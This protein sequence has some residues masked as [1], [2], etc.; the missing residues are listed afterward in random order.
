MGESE[1]IFKAYI[2]DLRAA[3]AEVM[4]WW[5]DLMANAGAAADY[6][7][8]ERAVRRRWPA[9]P[10]SHPRVLAVYRHYYLI[11]DALNDRIID[12]PA[13]ASEE[14]DD[15]DNWGEHDAAGEV[16]LVDPRI[17][18]LDNLEPVDPQLAQF[19]KYLVFSPIGADPDDETA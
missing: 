11:L 18:L 19:M 5:S 13:A 2:S 15:E 12:Q 14:P 9:G 16:S 6:A 17:T 1:D 7:G 3:Q 10:V 4:Q 8:A